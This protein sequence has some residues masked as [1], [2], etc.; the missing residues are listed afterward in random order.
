M[1]ALDKLDLGRTFVD[2]AVVQLEQ[3]ETFCRQ[4]PVDLMDPVQEV[5]RFLDLLAHHVQQP[6]VV[7][8]SHELIGQPP[9][10]DVLLVEARD[11]RIVIGDQDAVAAGLQGGAYHGQRQGQFR[12][13]L[14]QSVP[15]RHQHPLGL[16]ACPQNVLRVLQVDRAQPAVFVVVALHHR[17]SEKRCAS[18]VAS[19]RARMGR[20]IRPGG[21]VGICM[22]LYYKEV[23]PARM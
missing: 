17:P 14:F 5:L 11:T 4:A 7:A 2:P 22:V 13:F 23:R 15:G 19:T 3:V 16:L 8:K 1:L 21:T 6:F 12:R 18:A 10:P 9:H 20:G